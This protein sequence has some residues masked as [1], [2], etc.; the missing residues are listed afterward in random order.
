MIQ[1]L[2]DHMTSTDKYIMGKDSLVHL[3]YH[4]PSH[5]GSLIPDPRHLNG[6]HPGINQVVLESTSYYDPYMYKMSQERKRRKEKRE[7]PIQNLISSYLAVRGE[8]VAGP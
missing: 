8:I 4:A 2:L 1:D 5:L 3:M 7:K 6:T